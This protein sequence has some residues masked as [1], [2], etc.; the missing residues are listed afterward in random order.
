[1]LSRAH[2]QGGEVD[3]CGE[4]TTASCCQ[5]TGLANDDIAI[6][7]HTYFH[8]N[9]FRRV[10]CASAGKR[11]TS[12]GAVS[13]IADT[14]GWVSGAFVY[15]ENTNAGVPLSHPGILEGV[16]RVSV[17]KCSTS[18]GSAF[19]IACLLGGASRACSGELNTSAG[20]AV[21][22]PSILA[23]AGGPSPVE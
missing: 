4:R 8:T 5:R 21:C 23:G 13:V 11:G 19:G 3:G 18:V 22:T 10:G 20:V 1:M 15:G 16:G 14:F 7:V 6:V 2:V 12:V 17:Y 9:A